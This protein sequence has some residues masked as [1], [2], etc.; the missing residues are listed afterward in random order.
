MRLFLAAVVARAFSCG[1]FH[2]AHPLERDPEQRRS[3]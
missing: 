1:R 2:A 3:R